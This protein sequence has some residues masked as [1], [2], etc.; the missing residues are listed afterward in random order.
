MIFNYLKCSQWSPAS[1]VQYN[2]SFACWF[3]L[4]HFLFCARHFFFHWY[5]L[6]RHSYYVIRICMCE[7]LVARAPV[8]ILVESGDLKQTASR[9]NTI[10]TFIICTFMWSNKIWDT[11]QKLKTPQIDCQS[12]WNVIHRIVCLHNAH[13]NAYQKKGEIKQNELRCIKYGGML[14]LVGPDTCAIC[15][16]AYLNVKHLTHAIVF[17]WNRVLRLR[18]EMYHTFSIDF[19]AHL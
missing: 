6:V 18:I 7:C 5:H 10:R 3:L 1:S 8:R 15:R 19:K 2:M 13:A 11:F 12:S 9:F 17:A 16:I 14:I 4:R